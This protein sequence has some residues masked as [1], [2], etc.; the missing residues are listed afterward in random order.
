MRE[1]IGMPQSV[2]GASLGFPGIWSVLFQYN[3]FPVT[4]ESG[5]NSV[6]VFDAHIEV[7][8]ENKIV[9]VDYDSPYVKGLAVTMT[10][11]EKVDGRPG[12]T[13]AGYQERK[14]RRTYEDPYTLEMFDFYDCVV[15]GKTPK[16]TALDARNDIDLFKMILRAGETN[17]NRAKG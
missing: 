17:Y 9:R 6:P 12:S 7:Y 15:K 5:I 8:S 11:R 16:T 1:I 3:G 13:P 10:I 2:L 4:Y 14:I